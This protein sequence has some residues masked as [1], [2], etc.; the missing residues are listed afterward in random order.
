[1]LSMNHSLQ[2]AKTKFT[3]SI[4]QIF[5]SVSINANIRSLKNNYSLNRRRSEPG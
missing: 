3:V 4:Q 5:E 2:L 1:M